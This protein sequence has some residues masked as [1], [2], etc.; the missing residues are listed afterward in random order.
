MA[1]D[2][3]LSTPSSTLP[4]GIDA[5]FWRLT[6]PAELRSLFT[7]I[8]AYEERAKRINRQ[9]ETASLTVPLI[10][11]FGAPFEIGL[12]RHP[13]GEDAVPS[14]LAGLGGAPVYIQSHGRASCL[15][16]NFTP[17]GA[18]RFFNLPMH[19]LTDRML[20]AA[21]VSDKDLALF[22]RR[23]ED[24]ESWQARLDLA[25]AYVTARLQQNAAP[26]GPTAHAYRRLLATGGRISVSDLS[27]ELGW[28][29]KHLAHR[30]RQNIGLPPK[31]VARVIRFDNVLRLTRTCERIDWSGAAIDCGYADQAHLIRDFAEF[32]GHSPA[33]WHEL[34]RKNVAP[35]W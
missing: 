11:S 4:P 8:T 23:I 12:G 22:I 31:A 2:T 18:S 17:L 7:D 13:T 29:R 5:G 3:A 26:A 24:L 20:P 16:I 6:A 21:D 25:L 34:V 30:F 15:Q 28:S 35:T 1:A 10:L 27:S 9:I 33:A 32:T 14:F 19:E